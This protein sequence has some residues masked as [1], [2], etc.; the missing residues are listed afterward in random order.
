MSAGDPGDSGGGSDGD[1]SV[2]GPRFAAP[3][4]A[5]P[6]AAHPD[7]YALPHGTV[8]YAAPAAGL[9]VVYGPPPP[10]APPVYGPPPAG[11]STPLAHAG[12]LHCNVPRHQDAV[13]CPC[14]TARSFSA[15]PL[16]STTV[17]NYYTRRTEPFV[18]VWCWHFCSCLDGWQ[19]RSLHFY[20]A[21]LNNSTRWGGKLTSTTNNVWLPPC[22]SLVHTQ[23]QLREFWII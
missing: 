1:S 2:S 7:G 16:S 18:D 10:G 14:Q 20:S 19:G 22:L 12:V 11:F 9:S 23:S 8:I 15:T 21:F 4:G 17:G 5:A 13:C 6:Y 3:P